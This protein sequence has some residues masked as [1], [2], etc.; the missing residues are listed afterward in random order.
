VPVHRVEHRKSGSNIPTAEDAVK[1]KNPARR[2]GKAKILNKI[3]RIDVA[4]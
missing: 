2:R 4:Y 1:K 3:S